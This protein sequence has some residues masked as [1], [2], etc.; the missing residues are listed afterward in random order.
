MSVTQPSL[1]PPGKQHQ[2]HW[3]FQEG[4]FRFSMAL[5]LL[6]LIVMFVSFPLVE[7]LDS[8]R[9][10]AVTLMTVVLL[11]AVFA[12]GGRRRSLIWGVILV[13]PA[14]F[15]Q[16][17][18]HVHPD[19][20]QAF[21]VVPGIIFVAYIVVHLFAFILRAHK[22]T[23]E[24]LYAGVANYILMGLLWSFVYVLVADFV[25][26]SFAFNVGP[27][28]ARNMKGFSSIYFSFVT[29]STIGYGDVVPVTPIVRML[30]ITEAP[31]GMF[32]VAILIARL[33]AL[34]ATTP[35]PPDQK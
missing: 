17:F 5:F 28:A 33:V 32:Y 14:I 13:T 1:T 34:Q 24:V 8:G 18:R 22:V 25:P 4:R 35:P 7:Q 30:A 21:V 12:V 2:R 19:V 15:A 3:P 26:D 6:A 16:W 29:L 11:S 10:V 27:E 9:V 23:S 20:N 31:S